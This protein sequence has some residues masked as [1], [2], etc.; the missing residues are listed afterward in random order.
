MTRG[1]PLHLVGQREADRDRQPAADDRVA[2]VEA[3]GGIED[4]HRAAAAAA[5]AL[6]LAVH[7]RHQA[8]RR[9]AARQRVA[10][11]A[12]RR[13]DGVLRR[14]RLHHADGDRLLAD[15]EV[16]EAADLAG[17]VELRALLL[18]A[19]DAQHLVQQV[20]RVRP[21]EPIGVDWQVRRS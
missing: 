5:A 4:V 12:I 19:A 17:A 7:L 10:V 21:I 13:D 15:V 8:V 9:D 18:E 20:E 1:R 3:R 11:L 14:Q 6:L 2:A 16:Q